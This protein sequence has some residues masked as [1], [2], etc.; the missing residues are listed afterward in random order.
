M[1]RKSFLALLLLSLTLA[2]CLNYTQVT[3]LKTD[4]SGEM[5]IHYWMKIDI[6]NDTSV[7]NK[8]GIFNKDSISSEFTSKYS[9]IKNIEVYYDY[10]D[11]TIHGKVE[12]TFTF[13]DSLNLTEPFKYSYF[14]FKDGKEN[15]KV[16]KQVA[17]SFVTGFG[18]ENQN[19]SVK[20]IYYIPG[21]ILAHNA[22]AKENNKLTWEY[23][24]G[25]SNRDKNI[26][27]TF[28][29]YKLKETP[30]I[31]YYMAGI[32]IVIVAYFLFRKKK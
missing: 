10:S 14:S 6:K 17:H 29:P 20:Y 28:I 22:D 23:N 26:E 15:T 31:I 9:K 11:S 18:L 2:G 13:I 12:F 4:G 8:L 19:L 1:K 32:M 27:V 7:V 5:F 16:F 21:K 25:E 3:T 30:V 24:L